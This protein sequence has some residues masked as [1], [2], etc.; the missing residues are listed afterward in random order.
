MIERPVEGVDDFADALLGAGIG[1]TRRNPA[2]DINRRRHRH[3]VAHTVEDRHDGGA[4][5]HGVRQA[6][7]I[8]IGLG[9]FL[10]EPHHVIAHVTKDTGRHGWRI[11]GKSNAAFGQQGA[12]CF[13]R[14]QGDDFEGAFGIEAG[15]AVD[16][17]LAPINFPDQV[18]VHADDRVAPAHGTAFHRFKEE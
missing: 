16:R 13:K 7:G 17:S 12:Q 6:Q 9:Q 5:Q 10:H 3:L 11:L 1:G 8:G 18:G 4:D 15:L 14:V 2:L